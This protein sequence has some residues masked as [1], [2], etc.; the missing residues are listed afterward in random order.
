MINTVIVNPPRP[1]SIEAPRPFMNHVFFG[2]TTSFE[3]PASPLEISFSNISS[4]YQEV[5]RPGR[6]PILIFEELSLTR[7]NISFRLFK[8]YTGGLIS[9]EDEMKKL[10]SMATAPGYVWFQGIDKMLQEPLQ[11]VLLDGGTSRN[12]AWWRITDFSMDVVYRN[13]F[14]QATQV[15]CEI[16][17]TEERNPSIP[18]LVLPAISYAP[19]PPRPTPATTK[20]SKARARQRTRTRGRTTSRGRPVSNSRSGRTATQTLQQSGPLAPRTD[21]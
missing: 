17:L 3:F 13:T 20:K 2:T 21:Q 6:Y 16:Q 18:T 14:N 8:K 5:P 19:D 1:I 4:A 11:P 7:V 10:R 12:T 9:V 15:D